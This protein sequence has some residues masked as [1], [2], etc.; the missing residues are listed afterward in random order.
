MVG[1]NLPGNT[2]PTSRQTPAKTRLDKH[3]QDSAAE[4]PKSEDGGLRPE[5][6]ELKQNPFFKTA[7]YGKVT[8]SSHAGARD[9]RVDSGL[10]LSFWSEITDSKALT[11]R[12]GLGPGRGR[13]RRGWALCSFG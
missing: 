7:D 2:V 3:S 5:S 6:E 9:K 10:K 13:G 12:Q 11:A 1:E 4:R 8:R